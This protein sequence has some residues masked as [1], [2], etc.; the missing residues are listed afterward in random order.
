MS[1]ACVEQSC[2]R[3]AGTDPVFHRIACCEYITVHVAP[4]FFSTEALGLHAMPA[5][6]ILFSFCEVQGHQLLLLTK[7]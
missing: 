4:F 1:G 7:S 6:D 3:R 5:A 2:A